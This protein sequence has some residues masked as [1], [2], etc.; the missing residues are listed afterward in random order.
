M[1]DLAPAAGPSCGAARRSPGAARPTSAVSVLAVDVGNSKTDLAL[2]T[3]DGSVLAALRGPSASHQRVGLTR[4]LELLATL[5]ATAAERSGLRAG[6]DPL[7]EIG[8]FCMAGVD[9]PSDVRRHA[10]G[11]SARRLAARIDVRNDTEAILRAGTHRGWGIAVT[12]GAGI[13]ALGRAPDGR[14]ARFPSLGAIS[15]DW[16]GGEDVGSAALAA[17]VRARDGRGPRTRLER[18]VPAHF[19]LARPL[20]VSWALERGR[21][22]QRRLAE[23][24]PLVFAAA[25]FGDGP[26]AAIVEQLADEVAT[27]AGALVRRLHLRRQAV[28]I[29][30]GGGLL[31]APPAAFLERVR[32]SLAGVAPRA[33]LAVLSA[34]PVLGAA[35]LGLDGLELGDRAAAEARLRREL[36][37]AAIGR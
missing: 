12:C 17:A 26:A 31:V 24:A 3:R 34:P 15:G 5:S 33:S 7:A 36:T 13:N 9:S 16:G 32:T 37:D 25:S 1:S 27:M 10:A 19:G 29:V 8:I 11:L 20:D 14:A 2:I 22:R 23:L 21:L 35:L 18:D 30:L 6:A 4:G 28:E